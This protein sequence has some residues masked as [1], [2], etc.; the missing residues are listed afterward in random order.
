MMSAG[1][2]PRYAPQT[3]AGQE[4]PIHQ[5]LGGDTRQPEPEQDHHLPC[6]QL[7]ERVP[8]LLVVDEPR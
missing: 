5:R 4:R 1:I 2:M 7:R 3:E 8:D 6:I